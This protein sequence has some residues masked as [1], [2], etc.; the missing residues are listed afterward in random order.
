MILMNWI[1]F[2]QW[3]KNNSKRDERT[4]NQDKIN[5]KVSVLCH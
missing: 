1:Y 2:T 5:H 3:K 4:K